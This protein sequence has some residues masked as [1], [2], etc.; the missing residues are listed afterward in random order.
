MRVFEKADTDVSIKEV[1]GAVS[2]LKFG[3]ASGVDELKAE[4]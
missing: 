3:K 4:F 1:L 2:R